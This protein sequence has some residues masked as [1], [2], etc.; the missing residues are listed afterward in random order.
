MS[1]AQPI[2]PRMHM[3]AHSSFAIVA[4]Q[5]NLEY[6][7]GL[8]NHAHQKLL[9]LEQGCT[10]KLYWVSGAFEIPLVVK[11]LAEQKKT[12]RHRRSGA[13]PSGSD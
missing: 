12:Q 2:R 6:V 4:S 8:V 10:I 11:L 9:N 5:Y 7:Q 1:T 3:R 13:D